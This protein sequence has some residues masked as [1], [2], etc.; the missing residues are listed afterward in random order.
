MDLNRIALIGRM[1]TDIAPKTVG[2]GDAAKQVVSFRF[3]VNSPFDD[4]ALWATVE[5]W[6]GLADV[7]KKLNVKKGGHLYIE[8]KL[9]PDK[10]TGGPRAWIAEEGEKTGMAQASFVIWADMV[11]AL[12]NKKTK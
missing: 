1:G 6:G 5:C 4:H 7:I 8:G 9:V 11:I 10:D 3:A 12:D 2:E